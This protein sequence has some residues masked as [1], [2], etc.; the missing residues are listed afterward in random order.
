MR[1]KYKNIIYY[2]YYIH[3]YVDNLARVPEGNTILSEERFTPI[4]RERS[5]VLDWNYLPG[6]ASAEAAEGGVYHGCSRLVRA[7]RVRA[8]IS[9]GD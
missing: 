9:L 2:K 6:I 5:A 7:V 1:Y 3:I 4:D 8:G